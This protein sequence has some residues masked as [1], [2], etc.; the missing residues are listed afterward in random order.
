MGWLC[1]RCAAE[2]PFRESRCR[3]C[4]SRGSLKSRM[5]GLWVTLFERLGANRLGG[6]AET[7]W[8][9]ITRAVGGVNRTVG[10]A[11]AIGIAGGMTVLLLMTSG[12]AKSRIPIIRVNQLGGRIE[13][14]FSQVEHTLLDQGEQIVEGVQAWGDAFADVGEKVGTRADSAAAAAVDWKQRLDKAGGEL[15]KKNFTLQLLTR[16][17]RVKLT[18]FGNQIV[19]EFPR[20]HIHSVNWLIGRM[21]DLQR[22]L[23]DNQISWAGE[24][25]RLM[26]SAQADLRRLVRSW[27]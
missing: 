14:R 11:A 4:L 15:E 6:F 20:M 12:V 10:I 2:N 18:T 7:I 19:S 17:I 8:D 24:A 26:R 5:T 22:W 21:D 9:K 3:A 27:E 13:M 16:G 1:P 25:V 23:V